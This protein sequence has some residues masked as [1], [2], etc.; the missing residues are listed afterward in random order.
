MVEWTPETTKWVLIGLGV[1]GILAVSEALWVT[2]KPW[3]NPK[4]HWPRL[5]ILVLSIAVLVV[6]IV[7]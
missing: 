1:L 7:M 2:P 3:E 6:A 5:V 4:A